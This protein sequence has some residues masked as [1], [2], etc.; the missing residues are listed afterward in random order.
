MQQLPVTASQNSL[1]L[2]TIC[3]TT[4]RPL[5]LICVLVMLIRLASRSSPLVLLAPA[6]CTRCPQLEEIFLIIRL[7]KQATQVT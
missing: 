6:F 3:L 2:I 1:V 7:G 4:R 5:V